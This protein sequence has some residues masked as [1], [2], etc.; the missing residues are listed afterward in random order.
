MRRQ[1]IELRRNIYG[2]L[3]HRIYCDAILLADDAFSFCRIILAAQLFQV[4]VICIWK[5]GFSRSRL[6]QTHLRHAL[7][8]IHMKV[9]RFFLYSRELCFK[10]HNCK[11]IL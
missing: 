8:P 6:T 7:S 1:S 10:T 4:V 11:I 3:I 9:T 5:C 2:V